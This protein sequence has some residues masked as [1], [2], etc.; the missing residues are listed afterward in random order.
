MHHASDA[1]LIA[2]VDLQHSKLSW[3][4]CRTAVTL[5]CYLTTI[6][7]SHRNACIPVSITI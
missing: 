4:I 7:L 6:I 5:S 3:V 1:G 2:P